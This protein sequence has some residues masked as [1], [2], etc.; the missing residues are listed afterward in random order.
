MAAVVSR[1]EL[2]AGDE[3]DGDVPLEDGD[4]GVLLHLLHQGALHGVA[5]G[6]GGMD[7]AP[8]AVPPFAVQVQFLGAA[9]LARE[10]HALGDEPGDGFPAALDHEAHGVVVAEPAAGHVGVADMVVE[11]VGAVQDGGDPPLG[12]GRRP[13]EELVLG[14][15]RHL[16]GRRQAQRGRKPGQPTAD[17]EDVEG[18]QGRILV[19]ERAYH[20]SGTNWPAGS[21]FAMDAELHTPR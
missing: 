14:D 19:E 5:G 7:D 6:I 3:V 13:L 2:A 11:G 1:A 16:A 10:G 12:V 4:A 9:R 20:P 17:D 8:V 21:L 18:A 15:E